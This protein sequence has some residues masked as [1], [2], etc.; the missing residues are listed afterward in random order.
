MKSSEHYAFTII[1]SNFNIRVLNLLFYSINDSII[2]YLP[3]FDLDATI[4]EWNLDLYAEIENF[5]QLNPELE[6]SKLLN[7]QDLFVIEFKRK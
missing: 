4:I 7:F 1:E 6:H 3:V 5:K 2:K